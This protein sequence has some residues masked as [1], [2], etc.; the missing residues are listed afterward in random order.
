MKAKAQ[1][2]SDLKPA[3]AAGAP[4]SIYGLYSPLRRNLTILAVS[5]GFLL[6]FAGTIYLPAME[7][8][9]PGVVL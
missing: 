1:A 7:V 5:I 6:T 4:P 8:S 9:L 2:A 3:E